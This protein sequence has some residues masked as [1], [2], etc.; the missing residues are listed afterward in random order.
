MLCLAPEPFEKP[1]QNLNTI[2]YEHTMTLYLVEIVEYEHYVLFYLTTND[3]QIINTSI[4]YTITL[5]TH[6][7]SVVH[8]QRLQ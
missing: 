5:T 4:F 3:H 7:C 2:F 1:L 6:V 8:Q